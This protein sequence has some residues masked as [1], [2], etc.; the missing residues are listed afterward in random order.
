MRL[1]AGEELELDE[2]MRAHIALTKIKSDNEDLLECAREKVLIATE[3][4]DIVDDE[5]K[6]LDGVLSKLNE[7][8]S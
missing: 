6:R 2:K 5:I 8:V 7:D 1:E 4:Y 3:A